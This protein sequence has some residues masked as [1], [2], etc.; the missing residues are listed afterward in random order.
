MRSHALAAKQPCDLVA[1]VTTR[2]V[3]ERIL[4]HLNFPICPDML[5]NDHSIG[6][7]VT[8]EPMP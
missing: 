8:G 2:D 4:A 7:D 1:V 3:V 5:S 6:G